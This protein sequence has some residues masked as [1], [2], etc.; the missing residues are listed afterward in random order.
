MKISNIIDIIKTRRK[1]ADE[2]LNK[3]RGEPE[4]KFFETL[5]K[6]IDEEKK[7]T[8]V[9]E[10]SPNLIFYNGAFGGI[11]FSI[12]YESIRRILLKDH[13]YDFSTLIN[14]SVLTLDERTFWEDL[15]Y[16]VREDILKSK[17]GKDFLD[18]L[19]QCE[20]LSDKE[21]KRTMEIKN[22]VKP[23]EKEPKES[24]SFPLA[25]AGTAVVFD[26]LFNK[27]PKSTPSEI[28]D[29]KVEK[30]IIE[31]VIFV[32]KKVTES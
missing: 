18:F 26:K 9:V 13:N 5:I 3:H 29:S 20:T 7:Y 21:S 6:Y 17:N 1:V 10:N 15:I 25:I 22:P 30:K 31:E 4:F 11:P 12:K 8:D 27:K 2:V 16:F 14:N 23:K 19:D 32:E 24:I 28:V